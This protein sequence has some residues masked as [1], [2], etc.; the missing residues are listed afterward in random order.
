MFLHYDHNVDWTILGEHVRTGFAKLWDQ[1][2][3]RAKS[4]ILYAAY[5]MVYVSLKQPAARNLMFLHYDHN[6]DWTRDTPEPDV[7]TL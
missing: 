1:M 5:C 4:F 2:A 3:S 7:F 6:V